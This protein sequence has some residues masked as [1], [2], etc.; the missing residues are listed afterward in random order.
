MSTSLVLWT[1]HFALNKDQMPLC[2]LALRSQGKTMVTPVVVI[3]HDCDIISFSH[4]SRYT[5]PGRSQTER[6][7]E[8]ALV[9]SNAANSC[10]VQVSSPKGEYGT[11]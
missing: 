3:T 4:D 10:T 5:F 1:Q 7:L 6:T 2:A 9:L 11:V 8:S